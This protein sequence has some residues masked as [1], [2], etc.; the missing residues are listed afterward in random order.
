[1]PWKNET[2]V[3]IFAT[4]FVQSKKDGICHPEKKK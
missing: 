2:V 4:Y 1:M 3:L